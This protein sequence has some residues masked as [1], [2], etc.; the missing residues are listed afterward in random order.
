MSNQA[1]STAGDVITSMAN[2]RVVEPQQFADLAEALPAGRSIAVRIVRD[3]RSMFLAFRL[4][5]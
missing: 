2:R 3:G 4:H 1:N 5:Q